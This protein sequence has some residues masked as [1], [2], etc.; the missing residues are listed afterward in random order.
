[1]ATIWRKLYLQNL[2]S[3][4]TESE[5]QSI[6]A[7]HHVTGVEFDQERPDCAIV[8]FRTD[9]EVRRVKV[10]F[11]TLVVRGKEI[12]VGMYKPKNH[13]GKNGEAVKE[14]PHEKS[15]VGEHELPGEDYTSQKVREQIPGTGTGTTKP[16][17][18]SS[19]RSTQVPQNLIHSFKKRNKGT[20][21]SIPTS[22]D[23]TPTLYL[24]NISIRRKVL[25]QRNRLVPPALVHG[26]GA[27]S[28]FTDP[29]E[30]ASS[31][32]FKTAT[33]PKAPI[34]SNYDTN[35][36]PRPPSPRQLA[37]PVLITM[38]RVNPREA[39]S[40]T[41]VEV[42]RGVRT[43]KPKEKPASENPLAKLPSSL[44]CAKIS[45]SEK[46]EHIANWRADLPST[47]V[48]AAGVPSTNTDTTRRPSRDCSGSLKHL[49]EDSLAA[50]TANETDAAYQPEAPANPVSSEP[51]PAPQTPVVEPKPTY[52]YY[53]PPRKTN[54]HGEMP[55]AR[56]PVTGGPVNPVTWEQVVEIRGAEDRRAG[57]LGDGFGMGHVGMRGGGGVLGRE[58]TQMGHACQ[59]LLCWR[60]E[61]WHWDP[62][63]THLYMV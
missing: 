42:T 14:A 38:S 47:T 35:F 60:M 48:P 3:N 8:G 24:P 7:P 18:A 49:I 6:F 23:S 33:G 22:R 52:F 58:K 26:P 56:N 17:S 54:V 5:I 25:G 20:T 51:L 13:D 61:K 59:C 62:R 21:K 53:S 2:P 63:P 36:P 39:F 31:F 34:P 44:M 15:E 1:M 30:S 4:A 37:A 19:F 50:P 57:V 11:F 46:N 29:Q 32:I 10:D 16:P 41:K 27:L 43:S 55:T 9:A 12:R 45:S 40:N 28:N